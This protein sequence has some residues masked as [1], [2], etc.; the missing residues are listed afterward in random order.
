MSKPRDKARDSKPKKIK[1][2]KSPHML[3]AKPCIGPFPRIHAANSMHVGAKDCKKP[4]DFRERFVHCKTCSINRA[5]GNGQHGISRIHPLPQ[6][7]TKCT[8][9]NFNSKKKTHNGHPTCH[10][11][12]PPSP[13]TCQKDSINM[14]M[15]T[16]NPRKNCSQSK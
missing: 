3:E 12:D 16:A 8:P 13:Q 2:S 15:A 10:Q 5:H 6:N 4:E 9:K 14:S 11:T 1:H 7:Y